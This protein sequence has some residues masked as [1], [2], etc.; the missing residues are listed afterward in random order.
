MEESRH[1]YLF[2]QRSK[3]FSAPMEL[4]LTE[5]SLVADRGR[6]HQTYPLK[7]IE[8]IRLYF[9]PRNSARDTF[10]CEVRAKDGS[11]LRFDN[12]SWRSL[13]QVE[14][15]DAE[16]RRFALELIARTAAENPSL[17]VQTGIAPL[18]YRLMQGA[19]FVL[20]AALLFSAAYA[21][22]NGSGLVALGCLGLSAYFGFWLRT[23]LVRN[24]PGTVPADAV[25]ERVL[26]SAVNAG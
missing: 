8:R 9:S 19:G 5:S 10:V 11:A 1:D 14:R 23:F 2:S 4:R 20:L 17:V 7:A 12:L 26:P 25:P 13:V 16:F 24:R 6:A 15:L 3:P 18:R 22:S 21:A